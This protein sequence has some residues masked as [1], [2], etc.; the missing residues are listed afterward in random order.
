MSSVALGAMGGTIFWGTSAGAGAGGAAPGGSGVE[1]P[2]VAQ[3]QSAD[4]CDL[5]NFALRVSSRFGRAVAPQHELQPMLPLNLLNS[6][7][8]EVPQLVLG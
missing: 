2:G 3:P 6:F 4:A 1:Q 8:L 5:P 7:G